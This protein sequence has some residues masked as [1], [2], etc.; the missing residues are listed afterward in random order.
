MVC[1]RSGRVCA[2]V[3]VAAPRRLGWYRAHVESGTGVEDVVAQLATSDDV[4]G[5]PPEAVSA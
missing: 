4:L 3:A 2:A 5:P 1:S